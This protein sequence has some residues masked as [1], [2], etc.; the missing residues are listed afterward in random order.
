MQSQRCRRRPTLVLL[1]GELG[2]ILGPTEPSPATKG[3]IHY[4]I[5]F[6]PY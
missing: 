6:V 2:Q 4:P 5:P 3:Q 1:P